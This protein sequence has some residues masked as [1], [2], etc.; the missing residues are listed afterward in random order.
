MSRGTV[1]EPLVVK[2]SLDVYTALTGVALV[3][4][5]AAIVLVF[6]KAG[7]LFGGSLFQ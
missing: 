1:G 3:A 2:P 5:I 7:S 6:L 4:A